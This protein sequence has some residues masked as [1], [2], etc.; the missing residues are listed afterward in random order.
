MTR[1]EIN[2]LKIGDTYSY[3]ET[4]KGGACRKRATIV[5]ITDNYDHRQIILDNGRFCTE[6]KQPQRKPKCTICKKQIEGYG[7]NAE[8][9]KQ[10]N[11]C[12]LCNDRYVIPARINQ[13]LNLNRTKK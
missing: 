11:C 9:I 6:K 10:G 5:A 2:A 13:I 4:R 8:P 3:F 1:T 12:D 7:N